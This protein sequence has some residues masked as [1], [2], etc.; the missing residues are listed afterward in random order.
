MCQK[1]TTGDKDNK[2]LL[3]TENRGGTIWLLAA[4]KGS[5]EALQNSMGVA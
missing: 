2:F 3:G 1:L 5:L 4:E